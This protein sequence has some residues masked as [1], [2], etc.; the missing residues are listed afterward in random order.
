MAKAISNGRLF[1]SH[2]ERPFDKELISYLR[3]SRYDYREYAH[4]IG[5]HAYHLDAKKFK[6]I[7]QYPPGTGLLLSIFPFD[8]RQIVFPVVNAFILIFCMLIAFKI[9]NSEISFY[10]LNLLVLIALIFF[11]TFALKDNFFWVNSIGPTY[12][13]L[14]AAGYLLDKKPGLSILFLGLSTIFRIAN[15]ILF[16]PFFII[17][18]LKEGLSK[19]SLKDVLLKPGRASFLFLGGGLWF[20]LVYVWILLGNPFAS[21]YSY[22][23]QA[24][25]FQ[26]KNIFGNAAFY[27]SFQNK[28]FLLHISILFLIVV[29]R[30]FWKIP[31]KWIFISLGLAVFNYVFYLLHEVKIFYYP[32]ASSIVILGIL[33]CQFEEKT[34]KKEFS[35]IINII[36]ILAMLL[37]LNSSIREF[38]R[39]SLRKNFYDKVK[40]YT[41]RFSAYDV[42]WAE[43][44][45]GTI[46]YTTGKASFRYQWGPQNVRDDVMRWL[47]SHG[48]RQAVWVSDLDM[49]IQ[50]NIEKDLLGVPL[51][52]KVITS[53]EFGK[54]IEIR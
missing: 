23:D 28:W 41:D 16:I 48:Y 5:P 10:D 49:T 7:N 31:G 36:G 52:Y 44:R 8:K 3:N 32:F 26:I 54:L 12:G 27:F 53:H 39:Q 20:Y 47:K 51:E 29:M 13:I 18:A 22:I 4:L 30:V 40:I 19:F 38:P 11:N 17:Y 43:L 15:A 42:I 21:T 24:Y 50:E 35:K 6:I 46:E 37:S 2:T 1:Q 45:S 25:T 14:L 33:L 34:K 9:K